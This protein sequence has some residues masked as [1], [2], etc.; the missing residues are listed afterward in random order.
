MSYVNCKKLTLA[1]LLCCSLLA[2]STALADEAQLTDN[3]PSPSDRVVKLLVANASSDLS[4]FKVTVYCEQNLT[5]HP[6]GLL[7][8]QQF[9]TKSFNKIN[10]SAS[11]FQPVVMNCF[12][13]ATAYQVEFKNK[14]VNKQLLC[15]AGI[16]N[17]D[18]NSPLIIV[19]ETLDSC[20]LNEYTL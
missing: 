19:S 5:K 6:L 4:D 17:P 15:S 9:V 3:L 18:T 7:W 20:I 13:S 1:A 11:A 2:M 16:S 14:D 12:G 8:L 10:A